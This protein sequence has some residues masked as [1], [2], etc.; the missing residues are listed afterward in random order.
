MLKKSI[1]VFVLLSMFSFSMVNADDSTNRFIDNKD[2]TITDKQTGLVWMKC[3][4]GLSGNVCQNGQIESMSWLTALEVGLNAVHGNHADWR[5]P[6]KM[7][8]LSLITNPNDK[9]SENKSVFINLQAFPNTPAGAFWTSFR[10]RDSNRLTQMINFAD[11]LG[12]EKDRFQYY[13]VRL[14]RTNNK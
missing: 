5:L 8:L 2:N 3:P 14:V 4:I 1:V 6:N 13:Y 11:G 9:D 7:E 10:R 12:Y